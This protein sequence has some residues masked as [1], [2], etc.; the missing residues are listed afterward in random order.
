MRDGG[1]AVGVANRIIRN[2]ISFNKVLVTFCLILLF[3]VWAYTI[4]K[5]GEDYEETIHTVQN[6]GEIF[7]ISHSKNMLGVS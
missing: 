7:T 6:D 3:V 1:I 2:W 5:I 4:W